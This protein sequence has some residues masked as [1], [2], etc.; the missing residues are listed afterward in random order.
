MA[1]LLTQAE[2]GHCIAQRYV[3]EI[4]T[5]GDKRI[6]LVDGEA[7]GWFSRVPGPHDHR[8]N[9]HVGARVVACDLTARDR[10]IC[11]EL[12]PRLKEEGLLFTGIDVIGDWLTEINVTSPTGIREVVPLQNRD[13]AAELC[14][15]A[16]ELH[17]ERQG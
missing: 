12:A 1:E 9:M 17:Q 14:D 10:Q 6:I 5:S 15:R 13:L 11:E 16:L 2:T 4:K 7:R 3:P 8:G